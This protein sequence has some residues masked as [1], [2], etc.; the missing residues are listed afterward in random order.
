MGTMYITKDKKTIAI[1]ISDNEAA[2]SK[3]KTASLMRYLDKIEIAKQKEL[4]SRK[5][6]PDCHLKCTPAGF[7]MRCGKDCNPP[8]ETHITN[9]D[10]NFKPITITLKR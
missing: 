2:E 1:E 3:K 9:R 5:V 10:A 8:K 4:A 7:C 6:C